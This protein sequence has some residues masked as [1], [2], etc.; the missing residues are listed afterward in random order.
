MLQLD[1]VGQV[2]EIGLVEER[3]YLGDCCI[4][5]LHICEDPGEEHHLGA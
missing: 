4:F 1:T 2:K 3:D 5:F